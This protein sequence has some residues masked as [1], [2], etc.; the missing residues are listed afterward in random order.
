MLHSLFFMIISLGSFNSL[1]PSNAA[2]DVKGRAAS[3]AATASHSHL[4]VPREIIP[5]IVDLRQET[6]RYQS[7]IDDINLRIM[8]WLRHHPE[9]INAHVQN[10]HDPST[11]VP[12]IQA[13][14]GSF[15]FPYTFFP[16]IEELIRLKAQIPPAVN[17][18]SHLLILMDNESTS[19]P[20]L[21]HIFYASIDLMLEQGASIASIREKLLHPQH[22]VLPTHMTHTYDIAKKSSDAVK[23]GTDYLDYLI[24]QEK[25]RAAAIREVL[26]PVL[27]SVLQQTTVDYTVPA[28]S[29]RP[30]A[31]KVHSP[32]A[33]AAMPPAPPSNAA[34]DVKKSAA[35]AGFI[36]LPPDIS[37]NLGTISNRDL[38]AWFQADPE[39][40]N[41]HY[42]NK[43]PVLNT[44]IINWP[45]T[46][47]PTI[48]WLINHKANVLYTQ[49]TMPTSYSTWPESELKRWD[50]GQELHVFVSVNALA[51]AYKFCGNWEKPSLS[52][53]DQIDLIHRLIDLMLEQGAT[54]SDI[55]Q[56]LTGDRNYAQESLQYF[57]HK[58]LTCL[59]HRLD[60]IS[61]AEQY[62][63]TKHAMIAQAIH[64]ALDKPLLPVL[65][66]IVVED[67]TGISK[68]PTPQ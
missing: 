54:I 2:A 63:K 53:H 42:G 22:I 11:T 8:M 21:T 61:A 29:A 14:L 55:Q 25:L 24:E 45:N 40:I 46:Y 3:R 9:Y 56:Q 5:G 39:R 47:L 50:D 17:L 64:E 58:M 37:R 20:Y 36:K 65:R 7:K 33:A 51:A 67:I 62:L 10:P 4:M 66:D 44:L 32:A 13:F 59:Q 49:P 52:Q 15:N 68:S 48:Q 34:A 1:T 18:I 41:Y 28:D 31:T 60:M 6:Y 23:L 43:E 30:P 35:N 12:L 16:I 19:A 26:E 38:M 27:P 57:K